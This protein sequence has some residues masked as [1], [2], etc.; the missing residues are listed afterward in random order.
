MKKLIISALLCLPFVTAMASTDSYSDQL[1]S[2][3]DRLCKS[4]GTLAEKFVVARNDGWT[5]NQV[6]QFVILSA[7]DQDDEKLQLGEVSWIYA[8]KITD[9]TV[10]NAHAVKDCM[11]L[12]DE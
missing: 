11:K 1:A 12:Q 10:A 5:Q 2:M 7:G 4:E 9:P 8:N 6:E 3:K